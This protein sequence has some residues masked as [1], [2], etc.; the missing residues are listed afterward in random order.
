VGGQK[1]SGQ[2]KLGG[3]SSHTLIFYPN[4]VVVE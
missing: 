3:D 2:F 1:F 4:R